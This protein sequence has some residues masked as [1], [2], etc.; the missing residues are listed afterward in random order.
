MIIGPEDLMLLWL[1]V[2]MFAILLIYF[3]D[4]TN[5]FTSM[6]K[7]ACNLPFVFATVAVLGIMLYMPITIPYSIENLYKKW[8][9]N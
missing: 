5:D 4:N 2:S 8:K 3:T 7:A 6:I 9:K 1:E